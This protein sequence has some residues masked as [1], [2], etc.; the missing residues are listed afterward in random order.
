MTAA[1]DLICFGEAMV[2]FNRNDPSRPA[3]WLQGFGGDT[4]NAAI[5]AARQGAAA[6]YLTAL[7]TDPFGD[8]L[9]ELWDREG[10]DRSRVLRDPDAFTA[11]YF[12]THGPQGHAFSFLRAGSAASRFGPDRLPMDWIGAARILHLS[13]ISQAIGP[14]ARDAGF[15]AIAAA[16]RGGARVSYDTNLRLKLWP[17][18]RARETVHT[19]VAQCDIALP[20]LDDSR[21]LTGL[22][23]ADRIV[24]FYLGLGPGIVALKCG[25]A[26]AV[27][28]TP[29]RRE[30]IAGRRVAAV[31]ATGAGDAFDGAFLA[32]LL[33][34]DGPFEAARY[35][36][37]AAALSTQGHGAVAPIPRAEAVR[38]VL[39]EPG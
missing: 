31:D 35:A 1:P 22:D 9:L 23:D 4:S 6:A 20:S 30:R 25:P 5:A 13:G 16:R 12:V 28:A 7:G 8:A 10:V 14:A 21:L 26:G 34:G 24:D 19:A 29:D 27:V 39:A 37:A 38:A 36:N 11:V 18:E 2:E 15:A 17:L 33:A 32:R 3:H